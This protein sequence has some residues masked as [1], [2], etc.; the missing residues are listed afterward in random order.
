MLC[1][2]IESM[3]DGW[4]GEGESKVHVDKLNRESIQESGAALGLVSV[5]L[6]SFEDF[7]PL[8]ATKP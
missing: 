3:H 1:G 4:V 8:Y 2:R 5:R 6:L 7:V